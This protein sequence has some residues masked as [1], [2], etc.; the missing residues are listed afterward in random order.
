[1]QQEEIEIQLWDYIDGTCSEADEQRISLLITTD[2]VWHDTYKELLTSHLN[3]QDNIIITAPSP[4]FTDNILQQLPATEK[5]AKGKGLLNMSIKTISYFF[6]TAVLAATSYT[7]FN[8]DWQFKKSSI[9]SFN[10]N[11]PEPQIHISNTTLLITA[12]IAII[13]LLLLADNI[14][15]KKMQRQL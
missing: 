7:I 11:I 12:F 6:I 14:F 15:R 10:I 3:L 5:T 1:M 13:L 9:L 8:T 2:K 4:K